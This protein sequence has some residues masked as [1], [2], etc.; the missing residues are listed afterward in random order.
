MKVV[1]KR[2][3][4]RAFGMGASNFYR[5][6]YRFRIGGE[7]RGFGLFVYRGKGVDFFR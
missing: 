2:N 7:E 4:V 1:V 5:V 6:F 3:Y